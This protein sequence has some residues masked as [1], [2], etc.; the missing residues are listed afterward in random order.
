MQTKTLNERLLEAIKKDGVDMGI[1]VDFNHEELDKAANACEVIMLESQIEL[2]DKI[3]HCEHSFI[4][5]TFELFNSLTERL[6]QL[7]P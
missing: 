4:K 3:L 5:T 2:L 7:K 6:K 1:T